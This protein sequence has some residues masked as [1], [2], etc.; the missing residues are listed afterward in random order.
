MTDMGASWDCHQEEGAREA[1]LNE[2]TGKTKLSHQASARRF[3]LVR[4]ALH[5]YGY[6]LTFFLPLENNQQK[7][8][9]KLLTH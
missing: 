2:L 8:L 7:K 6:R 3:T 1:A 9:I 5:V 4:G